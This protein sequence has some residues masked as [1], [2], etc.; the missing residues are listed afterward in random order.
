MNHQTPPPT[1]KRPPRR[2]HKPARRGAPGSPVKVPP[3]DWGQA[4]DWY[5]QLVGDEGSEYHR[6]VIFPGVLRLLGPRAG[7]RVLDVACGQGAWCRVLHQRGVEVVGVDAA[8]K[9]IQ[10]AKDR[11]DKAI[12]YFSCEAQNLAKVQSLGDPFTAATCILAI[13][14]MHPLCPVFES[15]CSRLAP[16]GRLVVVMTHPAFRGPK[17]TAWGWDDQRGV[18][19]RRV[20]RYLVP[21]KEPIVT[22][23]GSDPTRYTWTFHRPLQEYIRALGQSGFVVDA[24]EEWASH[25]MST[26]G[27]RAK[28]EN[29][30]RREIP[31]FLALRAAK[32][33]KD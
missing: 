7:E 18:Q 2:R 9:M 30:A 33:A 11:S 3:T 21:R 28:A 26:S 20:D 1:N 32:R 29:T 4:A 8:P 25:K 12:R 24:L 16:G 10:R 15:V 22:H 27:P 5:D 19:Y 17:C 13:Q 31:L 14:N 6:E 23:P